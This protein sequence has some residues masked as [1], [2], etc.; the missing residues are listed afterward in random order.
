MALQSLSC[1]TAAAHSD[2]LYGEACCSNAV[3]RSL[4]NEGYTSDTGPGGNAQTTDGSVI[5]LKKAAC[6]ESE[7][8][9]KGSLG[10]V[11]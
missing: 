2:L 3:V 9:A 5:E 7:E 10:V 4:Q 8:S 11:V 6:V 1:A